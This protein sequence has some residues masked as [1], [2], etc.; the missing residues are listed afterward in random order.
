MATKN[1][2]T[3]LPEG[4]ATTETGE[5]EFITD[6]ETGDVR[7]IVDRVEVYR[8]PNPKAKRE[9]IRALAAGEVA[10]PTLCEVTFKLGHGEANHIPVGACMIT[11]VN[12]ASDEFT[13]AISNPEHPL[14]KHPR[15]IEREAHSKDSS[16]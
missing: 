3:E 13:I 4:E 1:K 16:F 10:P 12:R 9:R 5:P 15:A 6:A 8:L 11:S 7:C 14:W 2:A